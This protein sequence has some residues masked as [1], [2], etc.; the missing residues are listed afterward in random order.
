MEVRIGVIYTGKELSV[1][2]DG[3]DLKEVIATIE[4]AVTG[5]AAVLWFDDAK[6]H[7]VGVPADKVA[8]VELRLD[9]ETHRVGFGKA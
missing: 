1:D 8:Y 3:N 2:V 5:D 9:D 7:R 6:G 4:H